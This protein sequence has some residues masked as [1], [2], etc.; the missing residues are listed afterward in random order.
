MI[1]Q[2]EKWP[3]LKSLSKK[4]TK[5]I[6]YMYLNCYISFFHIYRRISLCIM[7]MKFHNFESIFF[8]FYFKE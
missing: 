2:A 8:N 3:I 5:F 4:S 7:L 1:F 6:E